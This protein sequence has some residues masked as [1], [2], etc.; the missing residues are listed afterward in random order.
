MLSSV[1]SAGMNVSEIFQN[2]CISKQLA[3]F[4]TTPEY[5]R[6]LATVVVHCYSLIAFS[7]K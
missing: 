3:L 1:Y 2:L 6:S 7:N 4:I 5:A